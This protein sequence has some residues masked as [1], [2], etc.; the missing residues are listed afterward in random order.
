MK[1]YKYNVIYLNGNEESF[2]CNG[3]QEAIIRAMNFAYEKAWDWR[4]KYITDEKGVSIKDITLPD[5]KF[6]K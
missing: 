2:Y 4:I 5:Y 6:N 3:F 1:K